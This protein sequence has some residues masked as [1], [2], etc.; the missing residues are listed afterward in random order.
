ML[1]SSTVNSWNGG[2]TEISSE[3]TVSSDGVPGYITLCC[4][5][6]DTLERIVVARSNPVS[7]CQQMV[8]DA[9]TSCLEKVVEA[10]VILR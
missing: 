5:G 3:G 6:A 1:W 9:V 8:P 2:A 10:T 7:C 4:I